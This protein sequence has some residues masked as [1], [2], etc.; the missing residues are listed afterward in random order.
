MN[1]VDVNMSSLALEDKNDALVCPYSRSHC[2]VEV[3][4][5]HLIRYVE[6]PLSLMLKDYKAPLLQPDGSRNNRYLVE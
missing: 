4:L 5:P 1:A 2:I 6:E 3:E